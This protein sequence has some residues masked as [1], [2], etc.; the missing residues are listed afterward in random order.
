MLV[1]FCVSRLHHSLFYDGV[2]NFLKFLELS[3]T[4][5]LMSAQLLT[6]KS[7]D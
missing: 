5:M 1:S 6:S 2:P 4:D 3:F 7:T